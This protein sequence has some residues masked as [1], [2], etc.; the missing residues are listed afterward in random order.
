MS[1]PDVSGTM[2]QNTIEL[3]IISDDLYNS[4]LPQNSNVIVVVNFKIK[5]KNVKVIGLSSSIILYTLKNKGA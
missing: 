5:L 3:I 2:Q 1:T 4:T